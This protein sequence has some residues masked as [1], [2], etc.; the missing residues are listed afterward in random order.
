MDISKSPSIVNN[1]KICQLRPTFNTIGPRSVIGFMKWHSILMA[2][3]W[4]I[5]L[6]L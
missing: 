2:T 5:I 1:R 6:P 4:I 3:G